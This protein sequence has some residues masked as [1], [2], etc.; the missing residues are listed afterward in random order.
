MLIYLQIPLPPFANRHGAAAARGAHN[1]EVTGSK[2]VAG[3]FFPFCTTRLFFPLIFG[4]KFDE[5]CFRFYQIP[6][7]CSAAGPHL[8]GAAP[9]LLRMTARRCEAGVYTGCIYIY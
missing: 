1:S 4:P 8:R 7:L 6:V 3:I 2:P 5:E 9:L